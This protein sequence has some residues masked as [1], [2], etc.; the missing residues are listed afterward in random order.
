MQMCGKGCNYKMALRFKGGKPVPP[1]QH[2]HR[3]RPAQFSL[4]WQFYE[5]V[6]VTG[7]FFHTHSVTYLERRSK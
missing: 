6:A 4:L 3:P 1:R 2:E 7:V 5:G